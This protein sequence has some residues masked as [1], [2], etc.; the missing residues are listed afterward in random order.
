ME[1]TAP[2]PAVPRTLSALAEALP[3]WE[4]PPWLRG[5]GPFRVSQPAVELFP[6]AIWSSLLA[7]HSRNPPASQLLYA[8]PLGF[9]P[10]REALAAYLRSARAV[11]CEPEQIVVV[12]GSQQ[13]LDLAARV[14]FDPGDEVWMEEP[15]YGG[16]RAAF[17]LAGA[18]L[19]PGV[20]RSQGY[21]QV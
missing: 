9:F 8:D 1:E 5:V 19:V 17:S 14:L 2:A 6:L 10:F 4:R 13:A 7:R 15:G 20:Q 21:R 16:S 12:S 3:P 18:R 11:R